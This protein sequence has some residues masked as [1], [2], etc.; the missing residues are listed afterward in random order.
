[1]EQ[2]GT[3]MQTDSDEQMIQEAYQALVDGYLNSNH[4]KNR[5]RFYFN[6]RSVAA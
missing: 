6:C 4:R 2:E 3:Y 5:P 1:M